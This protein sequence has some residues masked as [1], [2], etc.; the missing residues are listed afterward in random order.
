LRVV[1]EYLSELR[2]LRI[3]AM[4]GGPSGEYRMQVQIFDERGCRF[5][6]ERRIHFVDGESELIITPLVGG[7]IGVGG[8]LRVTIDGEALPPISLCARGA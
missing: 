5:A 6:S 8:E 4:M 1:T 3:D 2:T 7:G